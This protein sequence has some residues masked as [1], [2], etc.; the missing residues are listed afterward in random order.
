MAATKA[1]TPPRE[2]LTDDAENFAIDERAL[3]HFIDEK[4]KIVD[5]IKRREATIEEALRHDKNDA[6]IPND[7][8]FIELH[9]AILRG[10]EDAIAGFKKRVDA[11]RSRLA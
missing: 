4:K 11:D 7:R 3:A 6:N 8:D 9:K 10:I 2:I 1:P 5:K